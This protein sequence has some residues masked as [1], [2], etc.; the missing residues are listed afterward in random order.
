MTA[1]R[2]AGRR[3]RRSR[4]PP[5]ILGE[6]GDLLLQFR[7]ATRAWTSLNADDADDADLLRV[8]PVPARGQLNQLENANDANC[9]E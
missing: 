9:R 4:T 1:V 5:V 7:H 8:R 6:A 3:S 2:C